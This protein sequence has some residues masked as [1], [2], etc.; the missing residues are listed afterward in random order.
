MILSIHAI[1]GAIL[2]S[3]SDNL[4]QIIILSIV[5]HYFL[6]SIPHV[7]YK[8]ENIKNGNLKMATKEFTKIF[9]DLLLGLIVILYIIQD[10]SFNQSILILT[11][12]FFALLPDGLYFFDCLVKNKDR[13]IFTKF[14]KNHTVFHKKTHSVI[15]NKIITIPSQIVIILILAYIIL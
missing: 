13:N 10:Q 11:G 14:L 5:S 2:A 8:I 3:N 9:F 7:E 1:A 15:S 6:D 4:G 12:S